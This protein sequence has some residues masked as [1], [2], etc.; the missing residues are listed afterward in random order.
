MNTKESVL[1]KI[2][3]YIKKLFAFKGRIGRL[4]YFINALIVFFFSTIILQPLY[5]IIAFLTLFLITRIYP[6]TDTKSAFEAYGNIAGF[7][8]LMVL[9]PL[10]AFNIIKR[11]HDI[12][13]EGK[14]WL[15]AIIPGVNFILVLY[16]LF[17][18]GTNGPNKYGEKPSW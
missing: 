13:Q 16:L 17:C 1:N 15:L 12:N 3:Q 5:I 6:V 11:L 10:Q 14:M 7:Y 4:R 8:M 18:E 9:L 2:W